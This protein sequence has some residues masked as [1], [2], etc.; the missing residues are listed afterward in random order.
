MTIQASES[1]SQNAP[2]IN[3]TESELNTIAETYPHMH[4]AAGET[5]FSQ[6][7]VSDTAFIILDGEMEAFREKGDQRVL[8][9][10]IGARELIGEMSLLQRSRRTATIRARTDTTI[11][12]VDMEQF[13]DILYR[14]PVVARGVLETV[15]SRM[16]SNEARMRQVN[17][18]DHWNALTAGVAHELNNP[19]AAIQRSVSRM[20]E[21]LAALTNAQTAVSRTPYSPEQMDYLSLLLAR[22]QESAANPLHLDVMARNDLEYEIEQMLE[23]HGVEDAWVFT[24]ALLN[25]GVTTA[26]LDSI[27]TIFPGETLRPVLE[28]VC[29]TAE[30]YSL[31]N[32]IAVGSEH[33]SSIIAGL[34]DYSYLDQAP[35]QE[36]NIVEGLENTLT[37]LN[38]SVAAGVT[39]MRDYAPDLPPIQ[40][41]GRELNQVWTNIILNAFAGDGR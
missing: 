8:L 40:G 17:E 13:R 16:R 34:K 9:G 37:M 26:D 3:I 11:I 33:I 12:G 21:T 29:A 7:D 27:T 15:T 41:Y 38:Q 20:Q 22:C 19:A 30:A 31:L 10:V 28:L 23:E 6:G 4:I 25:L 35:I 36:V 5:L 1:H 2:R 18:M 14:C 32:E 24:D 39:I